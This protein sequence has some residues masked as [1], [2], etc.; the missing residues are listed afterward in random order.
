MTAITSLAG[1]GTR[2]SRNEG[3]IDSAFGNPK[4]GTNAASA[5]HP[6]GQGGAATD[7]WNA[8]SG[9]TAA[10]FTPGHSGGGTTEIGGGLVLQWGSNCLPSMVVNA[11]T[12][13]VGLRMPANAATVILQGRF[14]FSVNGSKAP[15]VITGISAHATTPT[16]T[17]SAAHGLTSGDYIWLTGTNSTPS[18]DGGPYTM[19]VTGAS[20]VTVGGVDT[21]LGAGTTGTGYTLNASQTGWVFF[22][23]DGTHSIALR[24]QWSNIPYAAYDGAAEA[25]VSTAALSCA[26]EQLVLRGGAKVSIGLI[27]AGVFVA[28]GTGNTTPAANAGTYVGLG[29]DGNA[30]SAEFFP[31]I[32]EDVIVC[33]QT[34][35]NQDALDAAALALADH[36]SYTFNPTTQLDIMWDSIGASVLGP[37]NG[38]CVP[39]LLQMRLARLGVVCFNWSVSGSRASHWAQ[40]GFLTTVVKASPAVGWNITKYVGLMML[41]AND[42]FD[43]TDVATWI[44]NKNLAAD[45]Y[46]ALRGVKPHGVV[47]YPLGN[48]ADPAGGETLRQQYRTALKASTHFAGVID[49]DVVEPLLAPSVATAEGVARWAAGAPMQMISGS[50]SYTGP[51]TVANSTAISIA[52]PA[53]VTAATHGLVTGDLA[54]FSNS[55][56]TPQL[57]GPYV[58]T[59]VDANNFTIP[60]NVT[61]ETNGI[62]AIAGYKAVATD[63][64]LAGTQVGSGAPTGSDNTHG[65]SLLH[66]L[67]ANAIL[68]DT[69]SGFAQAVGIASTVRY[70]PI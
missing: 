35:N 46:L 41:F 36:Q 3:I 62:A 12:M 32:P 64:S 30:V 58:I 51:T 37:T 60:V 28:V 16:I 50:A 24:S 55:T 66:V 63:Q 52:N 70:I 67:L 34:N 19:T 38:C 48:L 6:A 57:V 26:R 49:I 27:R 25:S 44:A 5:F 61:A 69:A 59:K 20:T 54:K 68:C 7:G 39:N 45:A 40:P 4:G 23:G 9:L 11:G 33:K 65:G 42:L 47:G 15:L 13:P 53:Q 21:H 17:F 29:N 22:S 43:G 10:T 1:F 56:T 31:Y 2:W 14:P 8:M 18:I